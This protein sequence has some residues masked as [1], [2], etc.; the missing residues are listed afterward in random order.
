MVYEVPARYAVSWCRRGLQ[1]G[2]AG[3]GSTAGRKAHEPATASE[4]MV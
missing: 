1:W 4:T 3:L 2:S